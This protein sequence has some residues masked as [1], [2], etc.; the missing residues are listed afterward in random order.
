MSKNQTACCPSCG[1]RIPFKKFVQLNNFS[2]TNCGDCNA[3]IEI[4]NRTANAVIAAVSGVASAAA[5][6]LGAYLGQKNYQSLLG[7]LFSGV[8]ISTLIIVSICMYAYRHS[9]LNRIHLE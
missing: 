3:R 4:S 5:V 6:V 7:G 2:V 9:K 1:G 8:V